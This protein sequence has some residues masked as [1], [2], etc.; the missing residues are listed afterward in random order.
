MSNSPKTKKAKKVY[1]L[2]GKYGRFRCTSCGQRFDL[3]P[4]EMDDY[5]EGIS[6]MIRTLATIAVPP[7]H[8]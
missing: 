4:D 8:F 6:S 1:G 3:S 5:E 2:P 7:D